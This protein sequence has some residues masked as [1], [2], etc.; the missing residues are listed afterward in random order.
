MNPSFSVPA[1]Y[2]YALAAGLPPDVSADVRFRMAAVADV[3]QTADTIR[4][5]IS[6]GVITADPSIT[7]EQAARRLQALGAVA[8][9]TPVCAPGVGFALVQGYSNF[10]GPDIQTFWAG[11][12]SNPAE[13]SAHLALVLCDVTQQADP[14]PLITAVQSEGFPLDSVKNLDP[15]PWGGPPP[16]GITAD[17]WTTVFT[18][19]PEVLPPN[20]LPGTVPQRINAFLRHL[21]QFFEVAAPV[22]GATTPT[23]GGPPQIE[24][25][26]FDVIQTFFTNYI[27]QPGQS[28]FTFG[29]TL[30]VIAFEVALEAVFP[31]DFRA[32][33]WLAQTIVTLN[34][35]V[36]ITAVSGVSNAVQMSLAEALYARGF[37]SAADVAALSLP[38]FTNA[39][40]GTVAFDSASAIYA[41]A[42]GTNTN[43]QPPP[44]PVFEP[45][46]ADGTLVSCVPPPELSPLGPPAYLQALLDLSLNATCDTVDDG[47]GEDQTV[48]GLVSSRRGPLGD[49]AVTQANLEVPLPLIDIVN[50]C[51]ESMV[52]TGNPVGVVHDTDPDTLA[53]HALRAPD[54]PDPAPGTDPF[55]HDPA[56]L[57]GALP[58]FSSP[59]VPVAVP[60]AYTKLA[61][62]VSA[63]VLPY[64]QSLDV[65]R[66]Y[67]GALGATRFATMR[68]FREKITELVLDPTNEPADFENQVWRFPVRLEI[69]RAYLGISPEEQTLLFTTT[70]VDP[71]LANLYGFPDNDGGIWMGTATLVSE[72]LK[73]TGLSY[74]ELVELWKSGFVPFTRVSIDERVTLDPGFPD[75]QPCYLDEQAIDF[76]AADVA[77]SLAELAIF[78]RL[79]K[80]LQALP[81]ARY[82]FTELADIATVLV[83]FRPD[84]T[85]NPDFVRQMAAFQ[86][87]RDEFH[88]PLAD[89]TDTT[90]GTGADRTHILA[91]W[92]PITGRKWGWVVDQL[93]ASVER[94]G[95][96]KHHRERRSPDF[97]KLLVQN[98]DPLSALSGFDPA[99]PAFTWHALPT[100]TLRFAEVLTKVFASRFGVGEIIYFC[101]A[102]PHLEGDDP[103]PLADEGEAREDPLHHP[104]DLD[105]VSLWSLR[106]KL[107]ALHPAEEEIASW[108]FARVDAWMREALGYDPAPG[109]DPLHDIGAHFFP[110]VL[111]AEGTTV[112]QHTIRFNA[113]LAAADTSPA[114]W[115][116]PIDGP[117]RYDTGTAEL[118]SAIP[119]RDAEVL[120]KLTHMRTLNDAEAGAV[121]DLYWAPRALLA[122][123]A[124][125]FPTVAE[126]EVRLIEE[127]DEQAR[128]HYFRAQVAL[129]FARLDTIT[130]HLAEHVQS[131]ME[132]PKRHE[133][134]RDRDHHDRRQHDQHHDQGAITSAKKAAALIVRDLL[135]DENRAKTPPRW[136]I[137]DGSRPAVTWGPPPLGGAFAALVGLAGTGLL[138]ELRSADGQTLRFREV[139]GPLDAFGLVRNDWNAPVPTI[140]PALDFDLS[141]A[142]KRWAGVRN[143]IAIANASGKRLG[144]AEG[145]SITW[146]GALLVEGAGSYRF[147]GGAP[148]PEGEKP[149]QRPEQVH[150]REWRV[151]LRRG[152]KSWVVVRH[153]WPDCD[154]IASSA[155]ALRRGAYEIAVELVQ[156]PPTDDD[157]EDARQLHTGFQLKYEGPDTQ[158]QVSTVPFERLYIE[159]KDD[160]LAAGV[161]EAVTGNARDFLQQLYPSTL[162]DV[163]RTYQRAFKA[164]L[165]ARRFRL[166]AEVLDGFAQSEL[167]FRL[168]HPAEFAGVSYL[169]GASGWMSHRVNFDF[170]PLP[171]L[172]PYLPPDAAQDDRVAPSV[173]REQALF[174]LWERTFD[175][176][177]LR[178]RAQR[179]PE[180]PVWLLFEE[181]SEHQP[182]NPAQLLRHLDIDLSHAD[183]VLRFYNGRVITADDLVNERWAIRVFF[184]DQLLR[185]MIAQFLFL[186]VRRARP[187]LWAAND[188]G[189]AEGSDPSGNA[190]LTKTVQDG[191]VENGPPRRYQDLQRLND[192]LR[193]R[194]RDA[195]VTYLTAL[196]RVALPSGEIA[197]LPKHLSELL[198]LDVEAGT[199]ERASR[200]E[201][202]VSAMQAFVQRARLGLE[203]GFVPEPEWITLWDRRFAT[204]RIWQACVR[205]ELYTENVIE[206]DELVEARRTE[207]FRLLE[208]QLRRVSLTVPVSGGTEFWDGN[209]PP[210]RPSLLLLQEREPS[211]MKLIT[212][213]REGL[214]LLGTPDRSGQRSWLAPVQPTQ[215]TSFPPPP[216]GGEGGVGI[217]RVA[218][219]SAAAPAT[220]A[221]PVRA[222]AA[223]AF[224]QSPLPFWIEA[225]IRLGTRF[226]RVAAAGVPPAALPFEARGNDTGCCS[227]C[228]RVHHPVIDE[229]YF[230][231][232]DTRFFHEVDQD[233]DVA[234]WHDPTVAPR[235]TAWPVT[236]MVHLM[237]C[238]IHDGEIMQPRR[239]VEGVRLDDNEAPGVAQVA[240]TGRTNDSLAFTVSTGIAAPGTQG[241]PAPGFRYDIATDQ[242]V[243]VPPVI[244]DPTLV[245]AVGGLAG[246]PYFAYF[247]PGAPLLPLTPFSEA[248]TVA[249]VLRAHCRFEAALRWYALSFDPL[250]DD[251]R[252]CPQ[253]GG[254]PTVPPQSGEG[255]GL[256][257][258]APTPARRRVAAAAVSPSAVA[259][260]QAE[261]CCQIA[262]ASPAQARD[263]AVALA[264]LETMLD[265]GDTLMRRN[266]PEAFKQARLLFD[267]AAKI[268]GPTP[269]RVE[270]HNRPSPPPTVSALV[271]PGPA[272]NPRLMSLYERVADRL[273]LI[274]HC[275]N[276][277]SS[278]FRLRNGKPDVDMP[279][280]GDDPTRDGW[281][282]EDCACGDPL[283]CCT[284]SPYRF[285][286]LT[287]KAYEL[288]DLA[289]GLGAE[290]MAAFEKGDAE[291]LASV[292]AGH[293]HQIASLT[294]QVRQDQWRDADWQVQALGKTKEIAQTR[295]RYFQDL[296]TAGLNA[297]EEDYQDLS[298]SAVASI[299]NA[300]VSEGVATVLGVIPDVF[301]GTV[302]YVQ[303]P[304][305]SKL[306][307]V[308][309]GV[310]RISNQVAQILTT[311]AGLR[312]TQAGWVRREQEWRHQVEVLDIEIEQIERQILGA[313]RRRD[314]A[315]R[316]LEIQTRQIENTREVM[317]ILR[318]KFTS[319]Q[320][321]LWLQRETA[322][323]YYQAF[324]LAR[325]MAKQAERAFNFERGHTSR[326]FIP[327]DVW[328]TLREGLLA[329]E[330]LQ[331][332]VRRMESAYVC[333]NA[334]EYELTKHVS[335]RTQLA[336]QFLALKLTGR[337]IVELPEWLFDLDYP[338]Q[339]MRRIKNVTL[340]IPCVVGPFVGVHC[341]LTLLSSETRVDPRLHGPV[342]A[343][344][345]DQAPPVAPKQVCGCWPTPRKAP[346]LPP[347][348]DAT[349]NGYVALPDDPRI[350]KSY[351]AKEAI[352]TSSGQA[353]AGLFEL[354]FR[355]ERYLPFEFSGAVSRWRIEL[356]AETNFFDMDT[357]TDVVMHVNY[358]AREAGDV[359]RASAAA[360]AQAHIPDDGRR[361]FDV[362]HELPDAFRRFET[363]GA[364]AHMHHHHGKSVRRKGKHLA[365][366]FSRDMFPFLPGNRELWITAIEVFVQAAGAEPSTH[367][368]VELEIA[369]HQG[370]PH[371]DDEDNERE[372]QCVGSSAFPQVYHGQIDVTLG[373]VRSEERHV[374][375]LRFEERL[376]PVDDIFLVIH[377]RAI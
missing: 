339:Y 276:A 116:T 53:G 281:R 334:R 60:S 189:V 118:W 292:R 59:A 340:T 333:D 253:G 370:C 246:Y 229:Y 223:T 68:A 234:G 67:L 306:A 240:F 41:L 153:H 94:L 352:A 74:C 265:W 57:Y 61:S 268:L 47:P 156:C 143:G 247:T 270:S 345:N 314:A 115:N 91:L 176:T 95:M 183:V 287:Q 313:E 376:G 271:P 296:I 338:G 309:S 7:P 319:Q 215:T 291:Y 311:T 269:L 273:A 87:L 252:W 124:F 317:D 63:P 157:L 28:G 77:Q 100:H 110:G 209:R 231:L 151:T 251:N 80:K 278:S 197:I 232:V 178:R 204:F 228:G 26:V 310:A 138:G 267:T 105:E 355:D 121:R 131:V 3:A 332:S 76:G 324:E 163:R 364:T 98:L 372:F 119:L 328:D 64:A 120:N 349:N 145:F 5:A 106:A 233:A 8:G 35:L 32:H 200:I 33:E 297:G 82:T 255:V 258:R 23:P 182:D 18:A 135:G 295:R 207:A 219:P 337:A 249:S 42:G 1:Q 185:K 164:L 357:L 133:H 330:R 96:V 206:C 137:D 51:L 48:G 161:D 13:V 208:D 374:A 83:L 58:A 101:T 225:A 224:G 282:A 171:L 327:E 112:D 351:A 103:F 368:E 174:D 149:D 371:H 172:D 49:L 321:F 212:G 250:H 14:Q 342:A 129:A 187:D 199:C 210:L 248:M 194:A 25:P 262:G 107:L 50:E 366:S 243:V 85:L 81:G 73:R 166:S 289:R 358:T 180:L 30:D 6:S 318:D 177:V 315:L 17:Q 52:G 39:L 274:Q 43:P 123:F 132:E 104:D 226:V 354:T 10:T 19:H 88:L 335:L 34:D 139:R 346:A 89:P 302:D 293:D 21:R 288:V 9:N 70:P 343:C 300:T 238:R 4:Q 221:A 16:P 188:P 79:W 266:A 27:A 37:T 40:I 303:L 235:L 362:K 184:A 56:K 92:G 216:D 20:T 190:N 90:P 348:P 284:G 109:A 162:R 256:V 202:A 165:F 173:E 78:I 257:A 11:V 66:T 272:I 325:C 299:T 213:D 305:G 150:H 304:V 222:A 244:A 196:G 148:T 186:D 71:L 279:Y 126:A 99:T 75:C 277:F 203:D 195:L 373:P 294:L 211:A 122:R 155:L 205:R 198:L 326:H 260:D 316:D 264:Y 336:R 130:H 111:A 140:L 113:P 347:P 108:T 365:L 341:K 220:R 97:L 361:I 72:F 242:A 38:D 217:V 179:A 69:A 167:G 152:Q 141:D 275:N 307:G 134:H 175:Y 254:E 46:N 363:S 377:Y 84:G 102:S 154:D 241:T 323:L 227:T 192:G 2:F 193:V 353:D 344:C 290:L 322:A 369:H 239:S 117:F 331:I 168:D 158:Q 93:I 191:L 261:L 237:W 230:W 201:E 114:A 170:N 142:Q 136:E 360:V 285:T 12:M 259:D 65:N 31:N 263:R 298:N 218:R 144:G 125:L 45:V 160:T 44:A 169:L 350:V 146:T 29:Q 301:V 24:L 159:K 128:W 22:G 55:P 312:L 62:D 286:F 280:F 36:R 127:G 375:T 359:L 320:L 54:S 15:A 245:S 356:P 367:Q 214:N 236:P 329:G 181:A 283:C 86:I 308:F 147:W